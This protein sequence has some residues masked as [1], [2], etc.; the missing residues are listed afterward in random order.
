MKTTA[1]VYWIL[2]Q[3]FDHFVDDG[4]LAVIAVVYAESERPASGDKLFIEANIPEGFVL[5]IDQ[6]IPN[7]SNEVLNFGGTLN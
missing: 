7:I 3:N 4:E 2:N 1:F 5:R 6:D